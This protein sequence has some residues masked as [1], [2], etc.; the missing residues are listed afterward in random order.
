MKIAAASL[1][2]AASLAT[3]CL[4][5][6]GG[7]GG[8][9]CRLASLRGDYI[10]TQ[11]GFLIA[12]DEASQR[13]PFAQAGQER[14]DGAG[15]VTG[16][17]TASQNGVTVRGT[18][19]GTYT[20]EASCRGTVVFTD[21]QGQIFHYDIFVLAGGDEFAFVQTDPGVVSTS[22]ERRRGAGR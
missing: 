13:T 12:G 16:A 17:Y 11:D 4:A 10:Y 20:V 8:P 15:H 5:D 2:L 21:D 9:R 18:Y 6:P 19:A 22:F 3:P 1:L 14:Y 7:P